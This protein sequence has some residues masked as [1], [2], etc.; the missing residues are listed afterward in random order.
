MIVIIWDNNLGEKLILKQGFIQSETVF[1]NFHISS[2]DLRVIH[3][4]A[5]K[6]E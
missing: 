2:S 3:E 6:Q 5:N 4:K 1:Q